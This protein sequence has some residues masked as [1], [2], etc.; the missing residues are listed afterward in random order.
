MN[1]RLELPKTKDE[2]YDLS[3]SFN[4]TFNRLEKSFNNHRNFVSTISHEFRT[5]LS[6]LITELELAKELNKTI[7]D[8]KISID[9]ALEDANRASELSSA[10]LD[11]AR[12]SY[13][14]SQINLK[15]IRVDEVL[16]DAKLNVINKNGQYRVAIQYDND[17]TSESSF[18]DMEGNPYLLQVAF[19]NLIENACKYSRDN[20]CNVKISND[21]KTIQ[22]HFSDNGAGI[23]SED[24]PHIFDLFFRGKNKK[25]EKGNGVGL[26][27]VHQII[28]IHNGKI[29]VKSKLGKGSVFL[30][31]LPLEI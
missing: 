27:I 14:I 2:L 12:A 20:T 13:D 21:D 11:F 19:V 23:D 5:P 30:V 26:S 6:I 17:V 25:S 9:N 28:T 3:K 1:K 4:S 29:D 24:I 16:A 31:S 15:T 10:L 18:F 8:Y 22:L 7:D